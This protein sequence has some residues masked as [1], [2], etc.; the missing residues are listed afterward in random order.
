MTAYDS[1]SDSDSRCCRPRR[2]TY[3]VAHLRP[4]DI[5]TRDSGMTVAHNIA[6][7]CDVA[8]SDDTAR[9]ANIRRRLLNEAG[10]WC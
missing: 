2:R 7:T 5:C 3:V 8:V 10:R 1:D 6:Y 4:H 9:F